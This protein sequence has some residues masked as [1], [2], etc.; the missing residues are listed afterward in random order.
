MEYQEIGKK[1][2]KDWV[3][4]QG[5][6]GRP[7]NGRPRKGWKTRKGFKYQGMDGLPRKGWNTK[8]WR[9][10]QEMGNNIN[11]RRKN[12]TAWGEIP[13]MLRNTGLGR[14]PKSFGELWGAEDP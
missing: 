13:R 10:Y 3:E 9:A 11:Q 8:E 2:L 14:P 12:I 4:Y 7:R 6:D 5:K 1:N